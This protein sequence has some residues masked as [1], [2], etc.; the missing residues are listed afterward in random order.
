MLEVGRFGRSYLL[1][2]PL[3]G[4]ARMSG[5]DITQIDA[6]R[7]ETVEVVLSEYGCDLSRL[8]TEKQF[9]SH[10]T[11]ALY[12]P[13]SGGKPTRRKNGTTPVRGLR[14]A[15]VWRRSPCATARPP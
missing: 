9:V 14:L 7:V 15:C 11:L 8:P 3:L 6:I 10:V 13:K 12:V 1:Y 5:V 2:P 4:Y